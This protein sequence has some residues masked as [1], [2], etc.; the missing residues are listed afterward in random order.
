ME[1]LLVP[2]PLRLL[3]RIGGGIDREPHR[4]RNHKG[5]IWESFPAVFF[6][7]S[8][9]ARFQVLSV[10]DNV[11]SGQGY[12]HVYRRIGEHWEA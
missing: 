6:S 11:T 1:I 2:F 5:S 3:L 7:F 12:A 8:F 10:D 4:G 9:S